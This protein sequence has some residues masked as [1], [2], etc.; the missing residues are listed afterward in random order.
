MKRLALIAAVGS[1]LVGCGSASPSVDLKYADGHIETL[2]IQVRSSSEA[3]NAIRRT[4]A[5]DRSRKG[6]IVTVVPAV[7]GKQ[8]CRRTIRYR[9]ERGADPLLKNVTGQPRL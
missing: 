1:I 2:Y 3:V 8:D 9:A 5:R 4:V 7:Q 6:I